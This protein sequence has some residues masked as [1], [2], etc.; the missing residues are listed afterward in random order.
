MLEHIP[1][2]NAS[3]VLLPLQEVGNLLAAVLSLAAVG[4]HDSSGFDFTARAGAEA[5]PQATDGSL[6]LQQAAE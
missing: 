6:P 3:I 5:F 1:L 4:M 2:V